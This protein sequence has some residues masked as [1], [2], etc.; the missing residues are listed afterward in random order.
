VRAL[1]GY[2]NNPTHGTIVFSILANDW[3]RTGNDLVQAIDQVVVQI[4]AMGPCN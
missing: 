1:S 2:L 3:S 4:N